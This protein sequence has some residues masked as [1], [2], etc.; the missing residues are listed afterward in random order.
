MSADA[1]FESGDRPPTRYALEPEHDGIIS[2]HDIVV[3]MRDGV[4]VQR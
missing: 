4:D 3:P 2:E 1:M